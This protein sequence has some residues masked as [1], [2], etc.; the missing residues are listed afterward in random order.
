[1]VYVEVKEI[2]HYFKI[3][4]WDII[5][6]DLTICRIIDIRYS[7]KPRRNSY[8][9]DFVVE[10]GGVFCFKCFLDLICHAFPLTIFTLVFEI[11]SWALSKYSLWYL[12]NSYPFKLTC[13]HLPYQKLF[14]EISKRTFS[15]IAPSFC[16]WA[17]ND[18]IP[19][20]FNVWNQTYWS[21]YGPVIYSKFWGKTSHFSSGNKCCFLQ[22]SPTNNN[23][24]GY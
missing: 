12:R 3:K 11:N 1:M 7:F 9:T 24:S 14:F 10:I 2:N 5:V 15:K 19:F 18:A 22:L 21:N 23:T 16:K 6:E 13:L 4:F 20:Y 8:V 17:I